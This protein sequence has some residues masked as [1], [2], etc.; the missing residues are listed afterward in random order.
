MAVQRNVRYQHQ[1]RQQV[2]YKA[3]RGR[4]FTFAD[5]TYKS[6]YGVVKSGWKRESGKTVFEISVPSNCTAEIILPNGTA[7]AVAAGNH[8]FEIQEA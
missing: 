8:K 3:P 6:V 1:K 4:A 2:P 5:A 7:E